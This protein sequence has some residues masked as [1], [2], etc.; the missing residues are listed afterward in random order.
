MFSWG[1]TGCPSSTQIGKGCLL[2][3][4]K[5]FF[6]VGLGGAAELFLPHLSAPSLSKLMPRVLSLQGRKKLLSTSSSWLAQK[7]FRGASGWEGNEQ[8]LVGKNSACGERTIKM[9][10]NVVLSWCLLALSLKC[11]LLVPAGLWNQKW[12]VFPI[13]SSPC[14]QK[15][16]F[17]NKASRKTKIASSKEIVWKTW[18]FPVPEQM[19]MMCSASVCALA[20]GRVKAAGTGADASV[21]VTLCGDGWE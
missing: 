17:K 15:S 20:H 18:H 13:S 21:P 19:V 16:L 3:N 2:D 6:F 8:G 14:H 7:A 4:G 9:S 5:D 10:C 1:K 12:W 11:Q